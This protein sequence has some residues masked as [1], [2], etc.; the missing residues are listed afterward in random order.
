MNPSLKNHLMEIGSN[1]E[2]LSKFCKKTLPPK[3]KRT[4]VEF[5]LP[6]TPEE[7]AIA[8]KSWSF[9]STRFPSPE[10]LLEC[11][12]RSPT[13]RAEKNWARL[14]MSRDR[15]A[16]KVCQDLQ[17]L[18]SLRTLGALNDYESGR[19]RRDLKEQFTKAYCQEWLKFW[20][21]GRIEEGETWLDFAP[22]AK[23]PEPI[24]EGERLSKQDLVHLA[25][26]IKRL[27]I[28]KSIER[29]RSFLTPEEIWS[30]EST[31]PDP[32]E[33]SPTN[34][35]TPDDDELDL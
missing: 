9:K 6:L 15:I 27:S 8:F 5:L 29:S 13:Q 21:D 17:L 25:N 26:T 2:D 12:G 32:A 30:I 22:K 16:D 35:P 11:C 7:V 24:P 20:V 33:E 10:E 28:G 14:E 1:L 34:P 23:I 3:V 4:Y 19:G 18:A 31:F